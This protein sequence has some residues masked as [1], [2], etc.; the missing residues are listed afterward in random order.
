MKN[1]IFLALYSL[2]SFAVFTLNPDTGRGFKKNT[3]NVIISNADC[4][5]AGFSTANFKD[6]LQDAVDDYW[7]S[8]ATSA[9]K[10]KIGS[11]NS[12]YDITGLTFAQALNITP[13]NTILAGCNES[14]TGDFD[15]GGG[16]GSSSILGA[17]QMS[18]S[19]SNC[20][21]VFIINSHATSSVPNLSKRN[22]YATIAHEL[23]HAL[24]LGH[25]S[26]KLNLMYYSV[27][28]KTQTWLGHDDIQGIT[29]L[30]PHEEEVSCLIGHFFGTTKDHNDTNY[31]PPLMM[32]LG[33]LSIYLL[34]QVLQLL[35]IKV[36][37]YL[38][39][40]KN[41]G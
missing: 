13:T 40:F 12:N 38:F 4:S 24:G 20:K 32:A 8:V 23:G 3:V 41:G 14:G 17:A 34:I 37:D 11:I 15:G 18:C 5:G 22:L 30:Y 9:L 2:S 26:S 39:L 25:S 33:F 19:G 16:A 6:Y 36:K 28:G 31:R 29:Y 7:N 35:T 10:V 27:G 21:A 1:F